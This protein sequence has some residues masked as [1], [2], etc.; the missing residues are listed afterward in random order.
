MNLP[1]F[2]FLTISTV[3]VLRD[4]RRIDVDGP[5][6]ENQG[7]YVFRAPGGRLYSI[8]RGEVDQKATATAADASR[9]AEIA[10]PK[11]LKVTPEERDRLLQEL[12]RNRNGTAPPPQKWLEAPPPGPTPAET[13]SQ[14]REEWR[15]RQEAR[16]HEE[17]VRRAKEELQLLRERAS[18]LQ[19]EISGLLSLGYHPWDFTYQTTEL[20]RTLEQIP[21]AELAITQAQRVYDQFRDDARRQG[22]LPG[23]LR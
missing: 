8:A 12:S 22:I 19:F 5:V 13:R 17:S 3:L 23:W 15:W 11:K 4:G 1:T 9:L 10:L 16:S 2:L 18:Q 21:V 7:R 6:H 14:A 20:A